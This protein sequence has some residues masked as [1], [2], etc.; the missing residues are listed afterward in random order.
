[1]LSVAIRIAGDSAFGGI[2]HA[3]PRV[4]AGVLG[5]LPSQIGI[6]PDPLPIA[7]QFRF[8]IVE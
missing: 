7:L 3:L 8:G 4:A 5:F 6:A 1:L 2:A